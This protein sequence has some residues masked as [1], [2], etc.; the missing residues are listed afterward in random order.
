MKQ[1]TFILSLTA[2]IAA[3]LLSGGCAST[4]DA[5]SAGTGGPGG[6]RLWAQNCAR[7]HN[8]RSPSDYSPAQWDT[9]MLHMRIRANL[10][11]EEHKKIL[12]FLQDGN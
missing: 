6:S 7:C 11:A 10:T 9:A 1:I 4:G 3:A 2:I 12:S 8:S 5:K